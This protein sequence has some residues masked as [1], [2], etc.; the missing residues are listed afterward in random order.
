M[1]V[2]IVHDPAR[3]RAVAT[4]LAEVFGAPPGGGPVP[5]EMLRS[6]AHSGGA[7]HVAYE[8]DEVLGASAAIFGPPRT[9]SVYSIVAAARESDRGVGLTLKQAQRGWA[10]AHDATTMR[11][12]FDPLVGRN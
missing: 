1:R 5:V 11:W 7:V 9:Q 6:V 3:L 4:L 10:L 8:E 2:E 12:T